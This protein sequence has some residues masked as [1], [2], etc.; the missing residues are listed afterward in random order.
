[1]QSA[2]GSPW[3]SKGYVL[4]AD[5]AYDTNSCACTG[6]TFSNGVCN[7]P[8]V[9]TPPV[10][11][12]LVSIPPVS[13]VY[14]YQDKQTGSWWGESITN[15]VKFRYQATFSPYNATVDASQRATASSNALAKLNTMYST[16]AAT[17][18]VLDWTT[19]SLA[20]MQS[21][22]FGLHFPP[23][24]TSDT[25]TLRMLLDVL[26]EKAIQLRYTGQ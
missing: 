16:A 21:K 4:I 24:T 9:V 13:E 19:N 1:V 14:Y 23:T 6:G 22:V 18:A 2:T 26:Y 8:V 12:A 10:T 3:T 5:S 15:G 25:N 7:A 20:V 11:P 17:N